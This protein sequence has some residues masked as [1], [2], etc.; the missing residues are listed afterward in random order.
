MEK[1]FGSGIR[2]GKKSDAGAGIGKNIPDPEHCFYRE[3]CSSIV[4]SVGTEWIAY[5]YLNRL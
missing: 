4:N 2:D 1:K 5:S 3:Y